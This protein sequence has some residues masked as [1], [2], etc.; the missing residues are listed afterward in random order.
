MAS[1]TLLLV[2]KY[3]SKIPLLHI[4]AELT[5]FSD[6]TNGLLINLIELMAQRDS[7]VFYL[8]QMAEVAPGS[9][10]RHLTAMLP[11]DP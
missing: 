8:P 2:I 9:P 3:R 7:F 11:S 6:T 1:F 5:L 10:E 4:A